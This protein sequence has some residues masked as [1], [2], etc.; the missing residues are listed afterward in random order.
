MWQRLCGAVEQYHSQNFKQFVCNV[1]DVCDTHLMFPVSLHR[2]VSQHASWRLSMLLAETHTPHAEIHLWSS[3]QRMLRFQAACK[4]E[5]SDSIESR[6]AGFA[7]WCSLQE[8]LLVLLI[9]AVSFCYLTSVMTRLYLCISCFLFLSFK[10]FLS[11]K[12]LL[13]IKKTERKNDAQNSF[14]CSVTV[15]MTTVNKLSKMPPLK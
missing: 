2:R 10:W 1:Y 14:N 5:L 6:T 9:C 4:W 13:K 12:Y 8:A 3:E 11:F 7:W 15:I